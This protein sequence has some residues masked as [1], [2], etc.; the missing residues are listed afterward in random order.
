MED[1]FHDA[2]MSKHHW[3]SEPNLGGPFHHDPPPYTQVVA[4]ESTT[5]AQTAQ[6]ARK[7]T[8]AVSAPNLDTIDETEEDIYQFV[9][10]RSQ[11]NIEIFVW[12]REKLAPCWWF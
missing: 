11:V 2:S 7:L 4:A 10:M 9:K 12:K 5:S 3:L 6:G 1:E 8:N